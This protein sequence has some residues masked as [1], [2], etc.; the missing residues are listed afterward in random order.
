MTGGVSAAQP[1]THP[2]GRATRAERELTMVVVT[3][4][5]RALLA[6][7]ARSLDTGLEGI[8]GHRL[9]VVD[10]ASEDGTPEAVATVLPHAT[11]V[12]QADNSG[13]AAGINA[14]IAAAGPSRA[15]LVLNPDV[16]LGSGCARRLVDALALP[17]TGIAVPRLLGGGGQL[18]RSLRRDPSVARALA[19]AV[20][21]GERAGRIGRLG[22]VIT[23]PGFY[24][25]SRVVDWASGAVMALSR[26]CVESVGPWDESFFLYSEEVDF[27]L[28]ARDR[29][30]LVRYVPDATAVHL[31]G[32]APSSPRLWSLM[33]VNRVR[34]FARRRGRAATA[35]YWFAV[36]LGEAIRAAT[37]SD[38]S[39]A[40]LRALAGRA[41]PGTRQGGPGRA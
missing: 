30:F 32:A 28:R 35:A 10:N 14:G 13:Y 4:N 11:L 22:E 5:S 38:R 3:H 34:L 41:L 27:A 39:R 31:G 7:F 23:D 26:R 25:A 17:A 24:E 36:A 19:A 6:E 29:G 8:A 2:A 12:R 33:T 1:R 21:G 20:A 16:R 9:V 37:G 15:V 18:Q 40:A